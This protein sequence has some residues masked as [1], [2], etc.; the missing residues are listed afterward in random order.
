MPLLWLIAGAVEDNE[1]LDDGTGSKGET[2]YCTIPAGSDYP[3]C[4]ASEI[5]SIDSM[6]P[7]PYL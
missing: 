1:T 3:T 5:A 7:C 4:L 6:T 2:D